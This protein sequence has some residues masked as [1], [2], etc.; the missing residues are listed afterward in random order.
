M[1]SQ[2][3]KSDLYDI[4]RFYK[5]SGLDFAHGDQPIN[6][7]MAPPQP[8]SLI[9]DQ[10]PPRP[11]F[12]TPL[13]IVPDQE[14]LERA[15][16]TAKNAANLD[17]LRKALENFEGSSLKLTAKNLV[18][19]TGDP[20]ADIMII[21]EA[22]KLDDDLSGVPFS[23]K[24]GILLEAMLK[25]VALDRTS[26]YLSNAIYW[27]PPGNRMPTAIELNL[28]K[29]FIERHIA[30]VNP[31]ILI[32]MGEGA[33]K[34]FLEQNTSIL[35]LRG[36]WN[37]YAISNEQKIPVLPMLHPEYLLRQTAQKKQAWQDLLSLKTKLTELV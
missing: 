6:H 27:R 19:G 2:F 5:E 25:T 10:A 36:V 8:K 28:C 29:P 32:L 13:H 3:T 20:N 1:H 30:L 37:S 18:F 14:I 12:A 15:K 17:D 35:R 26:A 21:G 22:P 34:A 4:L 31:K 7:F 11:I 33:T 16:S 23:G 24:N 9:A